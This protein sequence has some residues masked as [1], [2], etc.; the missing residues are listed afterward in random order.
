MSGR[1]FVTGGTGFLGGALVRRLVAD[2]RQ[3]VA[4]VRS[5]ESARAMVELGASPVAGDVLDPVPLGEGMRGCEVVYHAAGVNAF[6]LVDPAPLF[7]V[8]VQGSVNVVRAASGAGVRRVV[9]T[10]SA[11]AVGE[12]RGSVGREDSPHRGWFL[13]HYERAKHEAER[14][15]L[16]AAADGGIEVV[17]LLPSS[18]QGPGRTGGTARLI[19]DY[20]NGKLRFMV[21]TRMSL[22]DVADCTEAHLL[23]EARGRPAERYLVSGATITSDEALAIMARVC[24]VAHRVLRLPEAAAM[25]GAFAVEALWR[26]RRRRPPVCREMVRTLLHGHG[27]DGSKAA[28]EFGLAYTPVEETLRR[29]LRW[30][31]ERGHVRKPLPAL[32]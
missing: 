8:N 10:S 31:R 13:S 27:Y 5:S 6:C 29:T 11:A 26:L 25:S 18:V 9:Y 21:R 1:V 14:A 28:R 15:V 20:A 30:Y 17:C 22:V 3:V 24:G 16:E 7:R 4:L 19:L 32:D 2:G 23:A 12:A